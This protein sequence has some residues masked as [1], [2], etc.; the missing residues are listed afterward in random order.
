MSF[1]KISLER[2]KFTSYV[3]LRFSF[4]YSNFGQRDTEI[5]WKNHRSAASCDDRW[6]RVASESNLIRVN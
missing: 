4:G 6:M 1:A 5:I 3:P 2:E